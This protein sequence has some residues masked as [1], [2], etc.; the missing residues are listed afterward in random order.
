[1]YASFSREIFGPLY[2][3]CLGQIMLLCEATRAECARNVFTFFES[4]KH[5]RRVHGMYMADRDGYGR[6]DSK[7]AKTVK[8]ER[9]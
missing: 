2:P 9:S 3:K 5:S 8:R 1:M 4:K 6:E 7:F